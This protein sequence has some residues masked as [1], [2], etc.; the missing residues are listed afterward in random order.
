[1][2]IQQTGLKGC[3]IIKPDV[4]I[5]NRGSFTEIFDEQYENH[6]FIQDNLSKSNMGIFRGLHIQ[7]GEKQGKLVTCINGIITDFVV[8]LRPS[9]KTFTQWHAANLYASER[10]QIYVPPGFAHG[11]FAHSHNTIVHYR[12]TELYNKS[13]ERT[14]YWRDKDINIDYHSWGVDNALLST[15]DEKGLYFYDLKGE[16]YL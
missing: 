4:F 15:K 16:L 6:N 2:K 13:Q 1:M 9:S 7:L 10:G 12:T 5:D 3:Y 8:D 11:F 14:L